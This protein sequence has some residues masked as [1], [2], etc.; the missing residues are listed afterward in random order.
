MNAD[1]DII[2][3]DWDMGCELYTRMG[4]GHWELIAPFDNTDEAISYG[5]NIQR[6]CPELCFRVRNDD[7]I[8][9]HFENALETER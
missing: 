7:N 9:T 3:D 1:A 6:T 5:R 4:K 2:I 8:E